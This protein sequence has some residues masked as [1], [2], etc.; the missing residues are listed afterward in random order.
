[1]AEFKT[2]VF[3]YVG[4]AGPQAVNLA[5][6]AS[7]N[8]I[9]E[10]PLDPLVQSML[11]L[12]PNP[13]IPDGNGITGLL[14]FP[15]K[16]SYDAS[17]LTAKLD[18]HFTGNHM[19][20]IHADYDAS[21][22][23]DP[24]H[25]EFLPNLGASSFNGHTYL[26]GANLTSTIRPTIVNEAKFSWNKSDAPFAC[27][28]LD[29]L[30]SFGAKDQF[31]RARDFIFPFITGFGC[32][33][34]LGDS[35]GQGRRTGTWSWGDNLTWV[36]GTHTLKFGA[37]FRR[38]YENS[39]TSFGSRD[40]VTFTG[41]QNFGVPFVD[42]GQDDPNFQ[43]M[44]SMLFGI[45]DTE[46]QSQFFTKAGTRTA[47]DFRKFRQHEYGFYVQDSWKIRSNL[48]INLGGRYQFNGVPFEVDNNFSNLFQDPSGPAPA[49]PDGSN[50]FT[51]SAVGPGSG[52]LLYNNDYSNVE[53]RV[54]FSW[55]PYRNGKTAIRGAFGI[56]HDRI[57]GNVFGNARGNPPF[58]EAPFDIPFDTPENVALPPTATPSP[59]VL[60]GT[61]FSPTLFSKNIKM[62]TS[63]NWNV[64]LQQE[65]LRNLTLDI[66]YVGAHAYHQLRVVDG[67]PPQPA[68]VAQN[69]ANGTPEDLL[70]F[71]NLWFGGPGVQSTN[72]NAFYQ[73][74]LNE[75]TASSYYNGLQMSVT[76]RLSQGFQVQGAYT[77]SHS[78]DDA[79]DPLVAASGNK[80]VP[81]NSN[82][83]YQ[84]RGNS[85]FDIRHRV[86]I[87]Y[88]WQLPL[89]KGK[90]F[91]NSGFIGRVLEGWQ[92]SGIFSYQTGHP[93]DIFDNRDT[94]HTGVSARGDLIG[95]PSLPAGHPKD[96]TGVNGNA[97]CVS[98]C[99]TPWG[100]P[101][102]GRNRFYGPSYNNWNTALSKDTSITERV[103]LQFRT[104]AFNLFNRT[105]FL[106]PVNML[107]SP[108][109]GF[110][111]GTIQNPD[112]TSSARQLQFALKLLF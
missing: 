63:N 22:D 35:N 8:N 18:H 65:V 36:K 87:N 83:L 69:I 71:A 26:L 111:T 28:N 56:F 45:M 105:Q 14:Y 112:G 54:W 102:I 96:Q 108:S 79:S 86:V 12:Y 53:P 103:K 78:I 97:F 90:Q 3:T 34:L 10:L 44:A 76:K 60:D 37:E 4:S 31:G 24:F 66:N 33:S 80:S 104:E 67:N 40:T 48:T 81:R 59:V 47:D 46:T 25:D 95:T 7:P 57:F 61:G 13:T 17:N 72:N 38:V 68:L 89:G 30:N 106:Q 70:T 11:A 58:Q 27:G 99:P 88:I 110:S 52:R 5:D 107:D 15:S 23:P 9:N 74:A 84:E 91:A 20:S 16:S 1:M 49:L 32:L 101:G 19:L 109:F 42:V 82:A 94:Q 73:A 62:P 43:D 98:P 64:G 92:F 77:W 2:G 51:F 100:N 85:D 39:F 93:Y 41:N 29:K 21:K 50:G 6:P 55:D 75:T